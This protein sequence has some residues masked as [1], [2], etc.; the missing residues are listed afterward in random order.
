MAGPL[1]SQQHQHQQERAATDASQTAMSG[2]SMM[3]NMM[4]MMGGNGMMGSDRGMGMMKAMGLLPENVLK[5]GDAL[6]LTPEQ[7][8]RIEALS[9]KPMGPRGMAA[10]PMKEKP[11]MTGMRSQLEQVRVAFDKAPADPAAIQAAVGEVTLIHGKMM[12]EHL[13]KAAKVR[14]VLTP[15]QRD[16]LAKLPSC[17]MNHGA[18]TMEMQPPGAGASGEQQHRPP[19]A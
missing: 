4:Q 12:A 6:T 2:C 11:A 9:E 1:A 7:V 13:V 10:M 16:Q 19:T 15:A 17:T 8:S 3:A 14:D 18:G 5:H